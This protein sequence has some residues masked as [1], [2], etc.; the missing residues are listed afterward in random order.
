MKIAVAVFA[1]VAA[2]C[3]QTLAAPPNC[4][5]TIFNGA[6]AAANSGSG[7]S[8]YLVGN[9]YLQIHD[10]ATAL[11]WY[12]KGG[13]VGYVD[14]QYIIG[15]M[16]KNGEGIPQNYKLSF[17]WLLMAANQ[18]DATSQFEVGTMYRDGTGVK[19]SAVNAH[20]WLNLATSHMKLL[21][22]NEPRDLAELEAKMSPSEIEAA[23]VAATNW[24]P[25]KWCLDSTTQA[26]TVCAR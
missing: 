21:F 13:A 3:A 11:Q 6:K 1:V 16:Y 18:G 5:D 15:E 25:T 24:K 20:I 8:A 26:A 22:N 23:Q 10:P 17:N 14:A 12:L 4:E 7:V 2:T 9:C 19:Q